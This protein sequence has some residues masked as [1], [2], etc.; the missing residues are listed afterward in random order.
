MQISGLSLGGLL[1]CGVR[2]CKKTPALAC[3]VQATS[4]RTERVF[5]NIRL[6]RNRHD[7]NAAHASPIVKLLKKEPS[8]VLV[9]PRVIP[10]YF[11]SGFQPSA[12]NTGRR[13]PGIVS[14]KT[15]VAPLQIV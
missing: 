10:C 8:N 14:Y 13:T 9:L 12:L 15:S 3:S 4:E 7:Q 1:Q 5:L 2:A 6:S 11:V